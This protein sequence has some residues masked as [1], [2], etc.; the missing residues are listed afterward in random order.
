MALSYYHV[1]TTGA[2]AKTGVN[3]ANAFSLTEY[4]AHTIAA[5]NVFFFKSGTY[6]LTAD[7]GTTTDGTLTNPIAIIGVKSGT[8]ANGNAID[9][10]DFA[11]G[12]DRPYFNGGASYD[13]NLDNYGIIKNIRAESEQNQVIR[14]DQQSIIENCYALNDYTADAP[15]KSAIYG[16]G[17]GNRVINCEA[18]SYNTGI[19]IASGLMAFCYIKQLGTRTTSTAIILDLRTLVYGCIVN[20]YAKGLYTTGRSIHIINCVFAEVLNNPAI[21]GTGTTT[22]GWSVINT[23]VYSCAQGLYWGSTNNNIYQSNNTFYD[24]TTDFNNVPKEGD[25]ED[26]FCDFNLSSVD[27]LFADASNDDFSLFNGS[28]SMDTGKTIEMG[29]G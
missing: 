14:A 26:L 6:T 5:G 2:G 29:I 8:T 3:W 13:V 16:G 15:T 10:D 9:Y 19:D 11:T 12:T 17:N 28:P 1:T 4:Y 27:P 21:S 23:V 22:G 7:L 18:E 24:N 25:T 20:G